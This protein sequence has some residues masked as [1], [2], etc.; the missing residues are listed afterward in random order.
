MWLRLLPW[1]FPDDLVSVQDH[2][3]FQQRRA[4]QLQCMLDEFAAFAVGQ[5]VNPDNLYGQVVRAA[6]LVR[7]FN[8]GFGG[9][10]QVTCAAIDRFG[11]IAAA[12][13]F[14]DTIGGQ[15]EGVAFFNRKRP[16][17]NLDLRIN[18]QSSPQVALCR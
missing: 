7:L 10:V 9:A 6:L 5:I 17:I 2:P 8:D 1:I 11:D 14:I 16:I 3:G 15:Q 12:D 13:M 4:W 18:A